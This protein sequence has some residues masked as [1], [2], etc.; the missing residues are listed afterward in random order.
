MAKKA[1]L[2]LCWFIVG[3]LYSQTPFSPADLGGLELWLKADTGVVLNGTLV[4]QW[5]DCS[6]NNRHATNDLDFIRPMFQ[7]SSINNLPVISFDGTDDFLVFPE[8]S[9]LRTAFWVLRESPLAGTSPTRGLLGYSGALNFFRGTNKEFWNAE[10]SHIGVRTGSTRLNFQDINGTQTVVPND[11]SIVSL[12]TT[13]NVQATHLTMELNVFGWTWWGEMAEVILFSDSL[14]DQQIL[15]VENY[16]ANK[17]G[18]AYTAIPDINVEYGFCDTTVCASDGFL[19]YQWSNGAQAQ[20]TSFDHSGTYYLEATDY[21]GRIIYDTLEVIFPGNLQITNDTICQGNSFVWSTNL[22]ALDYTFLWSDDSNQPNITLNNEDNYSLQITDS[23]GCIFSVDFSISVDSFPSQISLGNDLQL[24]A[25]NTIQPLQPQSS[26]VNYLWSTEESTWQIE[27]NQSG[28]YW[29]EATN[30]T[31]CVAR[32]TIEVV[33]LGTAPQLSLSTSILCAASSAGLLGLNLSGENISSWQWTADGGVI[34][35]TQNINYTFPT[36]GEHLVG[37]EVVADNGCAGAFDTVLVVL[38]PPSPSFS[39]SLLCDNILVY[40]NNESTSEVSEITSWNWIINGANYSGAQVMAQFTAAGFVNI[41]F[42][43]ADEQ[44]CSA[45]LAQFLE[46]HAAPEILFTR[47]GICQGQLTEFN[48]GI[49]ELL[50]GPITSYHWDFGDNT[51]S[52]LANPTHFFALANVYE[53]ELKAVAES[54]CRDSLTQNVQIISPPNADFVITNACVNQPFLLQDASVFSFN[55]PIANWQWTVDES[56]FLTGDTTEFTFDSPGFHPVQLLLTTTAGCTAEVGQQIPVWINPVA[57]FT[58]AP[59]IGAAPFDVQFS[60]TS[61]F[62]DT[63]NWNFG[64]EIQSNV[65]SPT[66]TFQSNGNYEVELIVRS[67][68]GCSDSTSQTLVVAN[69][70]PDVFVQDVVCTMLSAGQQ[71][72]ARIV[73]NG[74]ISISN[75]VLGWQVGNEAEVVELWSGQLLPGTFFIYTFTSL[76]TTGGN[77]F[78]YL[79]VKAEIPNSIFTEP[80]KENNSFCKALE[81]NGLELFPAYP[82]PN[83]GRMFVRFNT[84]ISGDVVLKIFDASG[85]MVRD[86]VDLQVPKGFHQYFLDVS[87]LKVGIY[88]LV[89]EMGGSQAVTAIQVIDKN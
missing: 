48:E 54:G 7:D 17:Y 46:V 74:N 13:E 4:S 47:Q 45:Q 32:D 33:V 82:N 20:C 41:Q 68:A 37:V 1:A 51:S 84:G 81:E 14:T 75:L 64:D 29:I 88:S 65:L 18:P 55:D 61:L 62:G 26:E 8:V 21:F 3:H 42:S 11:Y 56:N 24:C 31:G 76:Q 58:F 77:E 87:E 9:N 63:F 69:P 23:S 28:E 30:P 53:V 19:A 78:P 40:F 71:I 83:D 60:N 12:V 22:N 2:V 70:T 80:N 79:C 10:F 39:T 35:N 36:P 49:D 86:L 44:G 38:T 85:N 52:A 50:T 6:G 66:H 16:L 67:L 72:T 57:S 59:E 27:I 25:G 5:T 73:N 34:G 89:L 15:Q 43:I